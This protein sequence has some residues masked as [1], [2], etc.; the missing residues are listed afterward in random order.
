MATVKKG[1]LTAAG[2]WWKHLRPYNKRAFWKKERK[3]AK[4]EFF[5]YRARGEETERTSLQKR[6]QSGGP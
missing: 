4:E 5:A 3:A 6:M 2:E 1:I